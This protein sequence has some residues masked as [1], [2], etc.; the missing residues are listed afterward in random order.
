MKTVETLLELAKICEV[1]GADTKTEFLYDLLVKSQQAENNPKLKFL[2]FTEFTSTQKMLEEYLSK[3]GYHISIL[4]GSMS[5]SQ[6]IA[7]Q[8][9]FKERS[10][11]LISTEA[12]G[13]GLNLQFCHKIGRAHV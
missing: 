13:E 7:V 12:G 2:I 5:L 4:N 3:R 10:Q 8:K 11:I 1:E 6:R 9:E